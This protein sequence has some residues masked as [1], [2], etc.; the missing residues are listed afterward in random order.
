MLAE[1]LR[2]LGHGRVGGDGHQ[3]PRHQIRAADGA[4]PVARR[5]LLGRGD[6]AREILGPEVR[7]LP[8]RP[9][10]GLQ[11]LG[12]EPEPLRR[13][14]VAGAE[15]VRPVRLS[16]RIDPPRQPRIEEGQQHQR[17]GP[18]PHRGQREMIAELA[19]GIGIE[20]RRHRHRRAGRV[21]R[22]QP[23]H[24][25]DRRPHRQ[26]EAQ[27][28]PGHQMQHRHRRERRGH[29]AHQHRPGLRERAVRHREEQ[30][31]RGGE[32]THQIE[33]VRK[34]DVG[35]QHE[36]REQAQRQRH[37][38]RGPERLAR[39]DG[40]NRRPERPCQPRQPAVVRVA[41]H[42][43]LPSRMAPPEPGRLRPRERRPRAPPPGPAPRPPAGPRP[44]ASR[45]PSP[46]RSRRRYPRGPARPRGW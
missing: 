15:A 30:H 35:R 37:P 42:M 45:S 17:C 19:R 21:E 32:R 8:V 46:P 6:Q 10:D 31:R 14:T 39:R 26:R 2:H 24:R 36:G 3:I 20:R 25:E 11:F 28:R 16:H 27:D 43:P 13:G 1:D 40:R 44:R 23:H 41:R 29:I 7:L 18:E 9:Q 4:Q 22:A 33:A 34:I 5:L 38:D 12:A